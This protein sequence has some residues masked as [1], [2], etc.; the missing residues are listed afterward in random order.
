ML[1]G[2]ERFLGIDPDLYALLELSSESFG[3]NEIQNTQSSGAL[4]EDITDIDEEKEKPAQSGLM[5]LLSGKQSSKKKRKSRRFQE[6]APSEDISEVAD[7]SFDASEFEKT[8]EKQQM[9]AEL[10]KKVFSSGKSTSIVNFLRAKPNEIVEVLHVSDEEVPEAIIVPEKESTSIGPDAIQELE[11][12]IAGFKKSVAARDLFSSFAPKPKRNS[13]GEWTLKVRLKIEPAK[14]AEIKQYED[15]LRTRGNTGRTSA[16]TMLSAL[17]NKKPTRRVTL[18]VPSEFLKEIEKT[19]NPLY[20]KSSGIS[21]GKSANSVFEMMMQTAS[22]SAFPKLT[23]IQKLKELEPP[24][25]E[26][27]ALHVTPEKTDFRCAVSVPCFKLRPLNVVEVNIEDETMESLVPHRM[28]DPL[29]ALMDRNLI[30]ESLVPFQ[31]EEVISE[32]APFAFKNSAHKRIYE[33]FIITK[34]PSNCYLNWPIKFQPPD[35]KSLLLTED[36]RYFI[37]KWISNAFA[38]LKTQSTKTPRNVKIREQQKRQKKRDAAMMGFVVDDDDDGDETEEDVFVPVLIIQGGTGSCKSAAIYSAMNSLNGYVHEINAGQQRARKDLYGSLKEFCTTQIIH[39]K[40]KEFQKGLVLF[41]DC[42]ILFEQDKTFWTVVQDVVNFSRRPIVITVNDVSVVPKNIWELADEQES[43]I[44]L[45]N[46][47]YESISQYLWLCCYSQGCDISR[48]MQ[49]KVLIECRTDYNYDLRKALMMC[50]WLCGG[51]SVQGQ[52]RKLVYHAKLSTPFDDSTSL[53]KMAAKLE[54]LSA[55]DVIG[56]N[57]TSAVL[58]DQEVNE[59]L[60]IYVVNDSLIL[61]QP[62]LPHELNIGDYIMERTKG[63][64][65]M[66]INER[67]NFNQLRT[68][69]L[70]FLSSRAKKLPKFL[71]DLQMLRTSSRIRSSSEQLEI[72]PETQGLPDTS[73]CY[74]IPPTAFIVDLAPMCRYWAR[75]QR[76]IILMDQQNKENGKDVCVET[77]LGWRRFYRNVNAVIGTFI[78]SADS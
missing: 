37:E 19:R 17:M 46:N 18:R 52:V 57:S 77:F 11:E 27:A 68:L 28:I 32:R 56:L 2:L 26:R 3:S 73:V 10:E 24:A 8:V 64:Y 15:P 41:E 48:S 72:P 36:S 71:L 23:P 14:L 58:H 47:D 30:L 53:E 35:L 44:A 66:I 55:S 39:L 51:N 7:I 65:P 50:Q 38:I 54:L 74:S 22:T 70:E 13:K 20:T 42:D 60:D 5:S 43:I 29:A 21:S 67:M 78:P 33:D 75:F 40:D 34:K 12:K 4:T 49:E 62:T 59:L 61:R 31:G 63:N 1:L 16:S 9:L 6:S 76:T 25:I 45:K 69:I